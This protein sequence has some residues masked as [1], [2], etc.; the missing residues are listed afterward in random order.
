MMKKKNKDVEFMNALREV[1]GKKP[2]VDENGGKPR[3]DRFI[4]SAM[5]TAFSGWDL[6][7]T[8]DGGLAFMKSR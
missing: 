8:K 6:P 2:L 4:R 5:K 1:M 3:P 7:T